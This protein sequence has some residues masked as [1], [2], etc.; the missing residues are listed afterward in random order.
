MLN[1]RWLFT[2][3][4]LALLAG[5]LVLLLRAEA[6]QGRNAVPPKHP[7]DAIADAQT[8][9]EVPEERPE[10]RKVLVPPAASHRAVQKRRPVEKLKT[11]DGW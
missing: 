1:K 3:V 7:H 6:G 4:N 10:Q 8:P 11:R 5:A 2:G 9:K